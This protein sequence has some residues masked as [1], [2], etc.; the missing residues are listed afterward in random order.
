[1]NLK[2]YAG[3]LMC[4]PLLP[5]MYFDARKIR[6]NVPKLPEA[7]G[8]TGRVAI[9]GAENFKLL[10]IGEST[11]AG[12][13]VSTHEE[14]F[15]GTL[16]NE[17]SGRLNRSVEWSVFAKTG[18]SV[19]RVI[20]EILSDIQPQETDLIVIGIGANDAFEVN[21]LWRWIEDVRELIETLRSKFGDVPIVFAN[22]PPIKEFPAFTRVMKFSIGNLME[23]MG[24]ELSKV[25]QPYNNVYYNE[26]VMR[27]STYA[28]RM[29]I[30]ADPKDFFSDGVHPSRL[31]YQLWARDLD[32]FIAS[33]MSLPC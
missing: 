33:N 20:D 13:G 3:I 5:I 30:K 2:Y 22:M 15:T 32:L 29:D 17:L 8:T 28:E 9:S 18:L 24:E 6:A 4:I 27:I 19:R 21:V 25:V 16:A 23:I 10:T 31:T 11:I 14:G 7:S 12:V 26:E 1:M